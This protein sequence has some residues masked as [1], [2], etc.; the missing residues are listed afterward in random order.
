LAFPAS[1]V[2]ASHAIPNV[3]MV[4]FWGEAFP[5]GYDWSIERAC[6]RYEPFETPHGT[7]VRRVWVCND[8]LRRY[9]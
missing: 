5:Y 6:T 3:Q 4:T 1:P 9:R 7:E 8:K 2:Q